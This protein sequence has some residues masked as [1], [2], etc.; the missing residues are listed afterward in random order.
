MLKFFASAVLASA[1]SAVSVPAMAQKATEIS[2]SVK[3]NKFQPVETEVPANVPVVIKFKN[4]DPKPME[5]E[6]KDLRFEKIVPGGGE[7][8]INVRAQKP[9]RYEF[10]D[11]FREETTR[12][13]LVFK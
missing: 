13:A 8:T 12:G 10:F 9:G 3:D 1:L 2:I 7:V 5:F 6:S 11:E 4:L